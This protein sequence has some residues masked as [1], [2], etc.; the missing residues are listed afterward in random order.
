MWQQLAHGWSRRQPHKRIRFLRW[1]ALR[2]AGPLRQIAQNVEAGPIP[3]AAAHAAEGPAAA[4]RH[5]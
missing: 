5:C 4:Q 1:Q 3:L 2:V